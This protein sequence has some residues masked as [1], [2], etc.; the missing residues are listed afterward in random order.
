MSTG[1]AAERL[2]EIGELLVLGELVL[3][4]RRDVKDLAAQRKDCLR[5]AITRLLGAAA[6][7][8]ALDDEDF[9]TLRRRIGAIGELAW[10]TQLL[11]SAL[12]RNLLFLATAY[13]LVRLLDHKVEKF[14]CR[15]RVAG[16]PVIELI[17][18]GVLDDPCRFG[19]REPVLG[20]ALKLRLADEYGH[21]G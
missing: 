7:G 5:G 8:I 21:H 3:A 10:Q 15:Q 18:D 2:Y 13:P 16:K 19:G 17:L 1:A 11:G 20:L 14:G 4:G 12:A 9:G 6:G